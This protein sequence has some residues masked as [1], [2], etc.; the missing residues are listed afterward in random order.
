MKQSAASAMQGTVDPGEIE[1]FAKHAPAWWDENGE[2]RPLHKLNPARLSF[3][4]DRFG[5]HFGRDGRAL[6]PF[7]G[8]RLLDI[9]CGG[10]LMCEPLTR[11]GFAVTGIDADT[12]ALEIARAH[13]AE[14]ALTID[15]RQAAAED[16]SAAGESFD[17][18]LGL[19]I[20]EHVADPALFL[21][22]AGKLVRPEGALVLS[23]INRTPKA[24]LLAIIG[25]EYLLQWLPRGTHRW[26]KFRRPAELAHG[27]RQAGLSLSE[28]RGLA[29][30]PW[31]NRWQLGRDLGVNYLLFA[32]KAADK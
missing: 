23:T 24:F 30:D 3:V 21:A 16:L 32:T 28:L 19:E 17:A 13:A 15:Y 31:H 25:A 4:R 8:L 22:A 11:L 18:V 7:A 5:R 29:F 20:V 10:G 26:N 14:Q 1:R 12:T 9:G 27:L 2:F 6:R